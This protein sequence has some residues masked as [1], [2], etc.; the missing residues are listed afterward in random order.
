MYKNRCFIL[1]FFCSA[2][3]AS[4]VFAKIVTKDIDYSF[5]GQTFRGFVAYDDLKTN[6]TH[7]PS[8]ILIIHQWMGLT[9]YEKMRA[10]ELA[11]AGYTAFAVD[12]YGKNI[13]PANTDEAGKLGT[14]NKLRV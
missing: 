1:L 6:S 7:K 10:L 2:F 9:D 8:G 14:V 5:E 13:R 3:F 11:K 4:N 12:V